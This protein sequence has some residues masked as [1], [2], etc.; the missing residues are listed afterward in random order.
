MS[1]AAKNF[2]RYTVTAALPYAN[3]PLHLGHLAGAYMPSDIY[4]RYLRACGKDV[5][6]I[7]G[8]DE[9]GAAISIKAIKEGI[10]PREVVDKYHAQLQ[11]DF[12]AMN[13][14]F[15]IYSR[16]SSPIHHETAQEFFLKFYNEDLLIEKTS[17]QLFDGEAGMFL[18]DRYVTGTCPKCGNENAYGDQCEKCGSAL[19]PTE[20]INPRSTITGS[21]PVMKETRHWFLPLDQY[22]ERLEKYILEDHAYWKSNVYGQCKSWLNDQ[23]QPRAI[24]RDLEWGVKV[25]VKDGEGKVLY[26]WFDAPIG[27]ISATREWAQKKGQPELWKKYWEKDEETALI[28]FIGKDN[29]V[30]HCIIFPAILMGHGAYNLPENVPANEF[31]NLEGEKLSTSR[32]HA[33]WVGEYAKDFPGKADVLR[34]VLTATMPENKDS[35]FTW[36]DFQNRNNKELL[37]LGNYVRRPMVLAHKYYGGIVPEVTLSQDLIDVLDFARERFAA[38][39]ASIGQ[40]RFKEALGE[41]MAI[42]TIGNKLLADTEPWKLVKTDPE[43]VKAIIY[44][45]LQICGLLG[46]AFSPFI[47]ESAAKI[48]NMLNIDPTG[49]NEAANATFVPSGHKL[50]EPILLFERIEDAEIEAQLQ[51]L[52]RALNEKTDPE[53]EEENHFPAPQK[54]ETTFDDFQ[55]MDIRIGT[56]LTAERVPKSDKLLMMSVDTGLD[57]RTIVSGVAEHF[58]PEQLIGKQATVL[59]NLAPRKIRG[60]ISQGMLLFAED[61]NGK[62]HLLNPE[63]KTDNGSSVN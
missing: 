59:V 34:Y 19:S 32:G 52:N 43:Q 20:L 22:Q 47:P 62:L 45:S 42:T 14:G 3:G 23:L 41:A 12:Q 10:T 39:G 53:V 38:I 37:D 54:D 17:A 44:T 21:I 46:V 63:T 55:K 31:L 50:N 58:Q 4:V 26:V 27:Y 25:P 29:I 61:D 28:H 33:V 9:H 7:C 16:T 18:A 13:I 36:K 48:N 2:K 24:T 51:K 40:F 49:W 15:D 56:I 6:F 57:V 5:V 11:S 35:D 60:V 8:S 30:F 1:T